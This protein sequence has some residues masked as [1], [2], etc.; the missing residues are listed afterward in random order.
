MAVRAV[1]QG[2]AIVTQSSNIAINMTMQKRGLPIAY[3]VT[4]GNQAQTGFA[5]IGEALLADPRVTALGLHIEGIGDLRAFERLVATRPD[6][7]KPIVAL[8]VGRSDQ[9]QAATVSHTA[10]IAGSDAGSRALFARLG[11]GQV[12]TIPDFMETLETCCM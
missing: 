10:S 3:V 4:A 5:E 12:D 1:R 7:G 8:K 11:V 6:L 2:V 9:A